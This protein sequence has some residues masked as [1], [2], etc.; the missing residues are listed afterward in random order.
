MGQFDG[1]EVV[2]RECG[3]GVGAEGCRTR[4]LG[5]GAQATI[6]SCTGDLCNI[7]AGAMS[8]VTCFAFVISCLLMVIVF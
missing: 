3:R 2:T 6:C 5:G 4:V 1:V 7:T 8:V